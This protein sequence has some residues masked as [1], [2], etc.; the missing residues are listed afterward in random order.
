[1]II[2]D[3]NERFFSVRVKSDA[4]E[5]TCFSVRVKSDANENTWS[6]QVLVRWIEVARDEAKKMFFM[7]KSEKGTGT[8][9]SQKYKPTEHSRWEFHWYRK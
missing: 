1:M 3:Q 9:Q 4:N 6:E 8:K 2:I 5:N 7:Q